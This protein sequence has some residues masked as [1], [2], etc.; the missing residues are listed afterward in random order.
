MPG[1]SS[2]DAIVNALTAGQT[3][4]TNWTKQF[5][6]T[7]AAAAGEVHTLFR[8]AGNPPSDAIFNAGTALTFQGVLD[9][10]T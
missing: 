1:F 5:N 3:F 2:S 7:T 6:P 9:S 10:T 4:K 8:G